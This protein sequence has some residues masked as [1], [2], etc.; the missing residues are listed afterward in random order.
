L[1]VFELTQ[2]DQKQNLKLKELEDQI[3]KMEE[4]EKKMFEMQNEMILQRS[5]FNFF[6]AQMGIPTEVIL[7]ETE[8]QEPKKKPTLLNW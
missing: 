7:P 6:K 1:T 4:M 2:R 8:S 3:Q 5:N